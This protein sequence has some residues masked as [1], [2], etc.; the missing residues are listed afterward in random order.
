MVHVVDFVEGNERC[1]VTT[2]P[3]LGIEAE[4]DTAPAVIAKQSIGVGAI[5]HR[6]RRP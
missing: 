2:P 4:G 1:H 3:G 6:S 5:C